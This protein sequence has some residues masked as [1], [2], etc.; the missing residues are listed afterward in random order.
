MELYLEV[1]DKWNE[2]LHV[3]V[4]IVGIAACELLWSRERRE[5]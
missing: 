1:Q 3:E 4:D 2:V 5:V